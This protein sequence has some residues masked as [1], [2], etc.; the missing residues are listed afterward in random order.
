MDLPSGGKLSDAGDYAYYKSGGE[1]TIRSAETGEPEYEGR[2]SSS[3][4]IRWLPE[5]STL[6]ITE[7]DG[8]VTLVKKVGS[9]WTETVQVAETTEKQRSAKNMET[10]ESTPEATEEAKD[11]EEVPT[12][13]EP[14]ES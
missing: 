12:A 14:G 8:T 4:D 5:T 9:R 3:S 7:P 6:E 11:T 1:V 10:S 2:F 13:E